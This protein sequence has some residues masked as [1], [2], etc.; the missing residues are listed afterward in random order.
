MDSSNITFFPKYVVTDDS[1]PAKRGAWKTFVKLTVFT[2]S[3]VALLV[4]GLY[5]V[6]VIDGTWAVETIAEED[7][8]TIALDRATDA[9]CESYS[10]VVNACTDV[11]VEQI[12]EN[13]CMSYIESTGGICVCSDNSKTS[14]VVNEDCDTVDSH[15]ISNAELSTLQPG[16]VPDALCVSYSLVVDACVDISVEDI[17]EFGCKSYVESTGGIC[18]SYDDSKTLCVVNEH[19]DLV[20]TSHLI[21]V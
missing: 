11:S 3:L 17:A 7:I 9:L 20:D 21:S 6:G 4:A 19:C 18:V 16:E 2:C 5:F 1:A 13:G 15:D 8:P 12:A 14:C 10:I